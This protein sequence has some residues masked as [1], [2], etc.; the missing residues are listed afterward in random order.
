ML[1]RQD[2]YREGL[3]IMVWLMSAHIVALSVWCAGLLYLPGLLSLEARHNDPS[4]HSRLRVLIRFTY[5]GITSP[6]AVLAVITG[7]S[8]VYAGTAQG[9]WLAAKLTAVTAMALFHWY[10]GHMLSVLGHESHDRRPKQMNPWVAVVPAALILVVLWL[11][12]AK[13]TLWDLTG[14]TT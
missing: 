10:C 8:L 11:V 5:V 12:L 9:T 4:E 6:A 3:N 13:P 14:G 7:A 2:K 1:L